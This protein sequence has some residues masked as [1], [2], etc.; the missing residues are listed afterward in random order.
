METENTMHD[1]DNIIAEGKTIA[2]V[3]YLTIIGLIAAFV[4]NNEKKNTFASYHI[5]QSLGLALTGLALSVISIIPFLGWVIAIFGSIF[6]FVLW[7]MGL[8]SALGGKQ[9][10]V[11]LL[12]EMYQEW[13]KG[14]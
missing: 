6:L 7:V 5:R 10:P 14:I 13:F 9:K 4:M 11:M 12:G 1:Q 8:L 2:V 3:A